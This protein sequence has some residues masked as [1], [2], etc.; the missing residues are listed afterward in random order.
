MLYCYSHRVKLILFQFSY[1]IQSSF[2]PFKRHRCGK[3]LSNGP[4]WPVNLNDIA[5]QYVFD[6]YIRKFWFA[7]VYPSP[8]VL[9]VCVTGLILLLLS[10]Y[11]FSFPQVLI[12]SACICGQIMRKPFSKPK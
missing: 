7:P 3:R 2:A 4:C 6:R 8:R 10:I 5:M 11:V 1:R 12:M 9:I